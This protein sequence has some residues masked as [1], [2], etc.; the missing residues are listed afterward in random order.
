VQLRH[1]TLL[2]ARCRKMDDKR[3]QSK[4]LSIPC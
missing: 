3:L 1:M 4:N 2:A